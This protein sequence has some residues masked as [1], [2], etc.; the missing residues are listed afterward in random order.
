M[1]VWMHYAMFTYSFML[2]LNHT[3]T[4]E[5][6]RDPRRSRL[7]ITRC[8]FLLHFIHF[9]R[10]WEVTTQTW[11]NLSI[12]E[13]LSNLKTEVIV[14]W[15]LWLYSLSYFLVKIFTSTRLLFRL[16]M[17]TQLL[18][19]VFNSVCRWRTLPYRMTLV[20]IG[21]LW[22]EWEWLVRWVWGLRHDL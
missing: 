14:S 18:I 21:E 20:T 4:A 17:C 13:I 1:S 16:S 3:M 11:N 8:F 9:F 7:N 2:Q 10:K 5:F 6:R 19:G 12:E 15:I 22:I